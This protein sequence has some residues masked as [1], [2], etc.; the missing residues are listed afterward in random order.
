MVANHCA[1][2]FALEKQGDEADQLWALFKAKKG[3]QV[4]IGLA[5]MPQER[6]SKRNRE[7]AWN[8]LTE[9]TLTRQAQGD[10]VVVMGDMNCRVGPV[11]VGETKYLGTNSEQLCKRTGN[12]EMFV[13]MLS[14]CELVSLNGRNKGS[15]EFTRKDPNSK[16]ESF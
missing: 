6:D 3:Q 1:A 7:D 15:L 12:G 13:Q 14:Q 16:R 2:F 10:D 11:S 4:R 9:N 8:L 5:Y